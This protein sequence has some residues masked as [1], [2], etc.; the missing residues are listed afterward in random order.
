MALD[1]VLL[2]PNGY[3]VEDEHGPLAV[4][5]LYLTFDVPIASIDNFFTRPN[6]GMRQA[7][8]AWRKIFRVIKAHLSELRT[9]HE[10]G[11][12]YKLLRTFCRAELGRYLKADGWEVA[13]RPSIQILYA[14]S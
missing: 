4:A 11:A 5:W 10:G 14:L 8:Q 7:R 6:I 12:E 1:P 9:R 3:F 13:E 2:S